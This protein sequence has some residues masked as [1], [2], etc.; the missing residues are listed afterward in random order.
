MADADQF[1]VVV[2]RRSHDTARLGRTRT[3]AT[4]QKAAVEADK[5]GKALAR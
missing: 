2:A 3:V 4:G 5:H 1:D